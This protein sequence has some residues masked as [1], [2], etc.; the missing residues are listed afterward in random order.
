MLLPSTTRSPKSAASAATASPPARSGGNMRVNNTP[1]SYRGSIRR[2]T[3]TNMSGSLLATWAWF[4][5]ISAGFVDPGHVEGQAHHLVARFQEG[6]QRLVEGADA[7]P[8]GGLHLMRHQQDF[9]QHAQIGQI[10]RFHAGI[11]LESEGVGGI[12]M[13][14]VRV[15]DHRYVEPQ[16]Q[17]HPT[18]FCGKHR[19]RVKDEDHIRWRCGK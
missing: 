18:N 13:T 19:E 12:P 4:P 5:L 6:G 11:C 8:E 1:T 15:T 17:D 3:R 9:V 2:I 10:G 7:G 14:A 16:I